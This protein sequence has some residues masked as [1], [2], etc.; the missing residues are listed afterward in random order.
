MEI[1]FLI[2]GMLL[3]LGTGFFVAVEFSLVALDQTYVQRAVDNGDKGAVPLLKCLKSL[4]TQ[5]SSCQLG[6][7]LTTLLT[8]Y[9][10]EPSVGRLIQG[11]LTSIG[12]PDAVLGTVSLVIAMTLA[13]LLSMLIG[14]LVPKNLAIALPFKIGKLLARPQLI[15]TGVFKPAIIVLNG[16]SNRVLNLFGLEAKEE[17]SGARTPSELSSLVRR[18]A[19]MGTLDAGTANFLARTFSFSERTA[20]DVMTPRIRMETIDSDQSV[21]DVVDLARRTGFSRFPLIADSPDDIRGVVHVKKAVAVPRN[22]RAGLPAGTIMTEVLRVPETVHLDSLLAELRE[23]NLQLAVVLDEYGGTAGVVTLEDLVEEIVGEVADEHDKLKP[24]VLQ[25]ASGNWFFPGLMRPD[26]VTDQIPNLAVPDE[27]GYETVAGYIMAELGRI[28]VPGDR[29]DVP[30][31]LLEVER[32]D[33]R[34]IDRV[35]FIPLQPAD[36]TGVANAAAT[37]GQR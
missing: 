34:R 9:V 31:G 28:A 11:P 20:A 2:A 14:E 35:S 1:Y 33:G 19:E 22:K 29:V 8:G 6:I 23:A 24:G 37:E 12:V 15:F 4:S 3:I 5:L 16:F 7:T 32:M 36:E 17:I 26:E 27:A 25:S 30:G 21:A 13:T 10:M 18:S